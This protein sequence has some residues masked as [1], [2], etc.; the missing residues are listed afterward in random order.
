MQ[1]LCAM[2]FHVALFSCH[3]SNFD[4][5]QYCS[6]NRALS[7]GMKAKWGFRTLAGCSVRTN[8]SVKVLFANLSKQECRQLEQDEIVRLP[9][10]TSRSG[11]AQ[12]AFESRASA[13][14]LTL[15]HA[16]WAWPKQ[17]R[18]N[19]W[20][21]ARRA[22]SH[23]PDNLIASVGFCSIWGLVLDNASVQF[24]CSCPSQRAPANSNSWSCHLQ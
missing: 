20:H 10:G 14:T 4:I 24:F 3:K 7:P 6:E 8:L 15:F 5:R 17:G 13:A 11:R 16:V 19:L 1:G 9:K 23:I 22:E 21:L 18:L 2:Q 12:H